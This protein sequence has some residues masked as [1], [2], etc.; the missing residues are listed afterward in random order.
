MA[1]IIA[2]WYIMAVVGNVPDNICPV[3]IPGKKIIPIPS[4]EFMVGIKAVSKALLAKGFRISLGSTPKLS[5]VL[6]LFFQATKWLKMNN[7]R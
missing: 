5:K 3:I 7:S 6:I 4:M 1:I 2:I